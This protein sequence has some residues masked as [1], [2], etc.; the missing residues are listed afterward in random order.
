[1]TVHYF[2]LVAENRS[3]VVRQLSVNRSLQ[4]SLQ[5]LFEQQE[6]GLLPQNIDIVPFDA[7]YNV[8]E[9]E[10]FSISNFTLPQQLSEAVKSPRKVSKLVITRSAPPHIKCIFAGSHDSTDDSTKVLF[11]AFNK[12]RLLVTG[13]TILHQGSTFQRMTDPGLTLDT[14]L[15]AAFKDNTLYFRSFRAVNS[16]VDISDYFKEATDGEISEVLGHSRLHVDDVDAVLKL[17]DA[18]MRR[19]FSAVLA[20][21]ILDLVTPRKIVNRAGKYGLA[22]ATCRVSNADALVFPQSKKEMKHLL[23]FLN[24]GYFEGELTGRLFQTNSQ[25][26]LPST[27]GAS[28]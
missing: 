20:S 14:K 22:L 8:D 21:G 5:A 28:N 9:T 24:E 2:A 1:M 3:T 15:I 18:W 6:G 25:R 16:I 12:S 13:L 19:R 23:T 11:Q 27:D 26:T 10:V 4:N 7:G 17:T